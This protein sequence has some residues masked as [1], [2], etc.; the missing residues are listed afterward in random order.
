MLSG[1]DNV[2]V[3]VGVILTTTLCSAGLL[4]VF[5]KHTANLKLFPAEVLQDGSTEA[6]R[7]SGAG[8]V[9]ALSLSPWLALGIRPHSLLL[10]WN[11]SPPPSIRGCA[12]MQRRQ[13]CD[14]LHVE[15]RFWR[16]RRRGDRGGGTSTESHSHLGESSGNKICLDVVE[17]HG[18]VTGGGPESRGHRHDVNLRAQQRSF[19]SIL[20]D[21]EGKQRDFSFST[22]MAKLR[23]CDAVLIWFM[24]SLNLLLASTAGNTI[25]KKQKKTKKTLVLF[26][27]NTEK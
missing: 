3:S 23:G 1:L 10:K 20:K 16:K 5:Q 27:C 4:L 9:G 14:C 18:C 15:Q 25:E 12:N 26:K 7:T 11:S 2:L 17:S 21:D 13:R 19:W 6:D 22:S 8:A 24:R